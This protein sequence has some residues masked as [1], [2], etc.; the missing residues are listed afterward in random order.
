MARVLQWNVCI[1]DSSKGFA[2]PGL[3]GL[4]QEMCQ[5]LPGLD[6]S[7]RGEISSW[8]LERE[9]ARR[10]HIRWKTEF[11]LNTVYMYVETTH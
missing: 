2:I 6:V 3:E 10:H 1:I 8:S 7:Q 4:Q 11:D 9:E 5:C